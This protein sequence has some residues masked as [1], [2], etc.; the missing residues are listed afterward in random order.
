MQWEHVLDQLA[1]AV[2]RLRDVAPR[3][4]RLVREARR[5]RDSVSVAE[6]RNENADRRTGLRLHGESKRL[7]Q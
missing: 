6:C 5:L 3:N 4:Q 2:G 7:L 1:R